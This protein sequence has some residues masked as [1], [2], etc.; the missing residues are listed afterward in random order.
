MD[1]SK[2]E[3]TSIEEI[4]MPRTFKAAL[5][6]VLKRIDTHCAEMQLTHVFL[7]GSAARGEAL[8]GSDL[9]ILLLTDAERERNVRIKVIEHDLADDTAYVPIQITVRKTC[10]FIDQEAYVCGFNAK[11]PQK[12]LCKSE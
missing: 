9:D 1:L 2:Y 8:F 3:M 6:D 5:Y 10:R 4:T 11:R 7:F 12:F